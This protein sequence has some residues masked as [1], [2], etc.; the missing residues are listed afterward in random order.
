MEAN[1][2]ILWN[3]KQ[4]LCFEP[5]KLTGMRKLH[6]HKLTNLLTKDTQLGYGEIL[7]EDK[8]IL[9]KK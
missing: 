6:V 7:V 5:I 1:I 8:M 9:L 4:T 3:L 2:N